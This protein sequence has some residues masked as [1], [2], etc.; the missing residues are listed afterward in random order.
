MTM[1]IW[2][3][4]AHATTVNDCTNACTLSRLMQSTEMCETAEH[5]MTQE[6]KDKSDEKHLC[7]DWFGLKCIM[8][9]FVSCKNS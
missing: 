1:V 6:K 5:D 9:R 8:Q 2:Y 4:G 3:E 7:Q